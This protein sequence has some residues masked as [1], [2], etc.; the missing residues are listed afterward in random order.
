MKRAYSPADI[1]SKKYKRIGWSGDFLAAFDN[2]E[3]IGVW[4][5]WGNSGNG[6]SS[7]LMQ[8]VKALATLHPVFF[9]ALEEGNSLTMQNLLIQSNIAE[10]KRKVLIGQESIEDMMVR[11]TKKKSPQYYFVDSIQYA[12]LTWAKYVLL[13]EHARANKKLLIFSS[14][15]DGKTPRGSLA[16]SVRYDADLKIWVEGFKAISNGRYNPGGEYVI[17]DERATE[18]WGTKPQSV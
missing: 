6:K 13:K 11:M 5:I 17:W 14:H 7:F 8:M 2:P 4:F 12:R 1:L 15:C 9:N 18:Y 3:A 16:D 10:V